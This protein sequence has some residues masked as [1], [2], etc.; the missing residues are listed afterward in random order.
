M[1]EKILHIVVMAL[2]VL[3]IVLYC[4]EPDLPARF[5]PYAQDAIKAAF[6][7]AVFLMNPMG[8]LE[9]LR[10]VTVPLPSVGER[11]PGT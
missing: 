6:F 8:V 10:G 1:T 2:V 7:V 5:S 4:F 11:A 3:M 9:R